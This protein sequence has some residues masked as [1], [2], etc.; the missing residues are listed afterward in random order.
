[1]GQVPPGY[2]QL[3]DSEQH[4]APGARR[5]GPANADEMICVSVRVR[6][7]PGAPPL[8]EMND[9]GATPVPERRYLSQ[10]EYAEKYGADPGDLKQIADFA[11]SAG[12]TVVESS[13]AR[14]TVVLSGT[15]AHM[16]GAFAVTLARYK[17]GDV[18]YRGREGFIYVPAALGKIVEGV[19]GLDNRRVARPA[20]N[21]GM[22]PA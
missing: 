9:W 20:G 16:Q 2:V 18:E 8:P 15:V 7:R 3:Q 14:R 11:Q 1:M 17:S 10:E 22:P 5:V 21:G 6:P 13:V 12:L 4:P 19:F